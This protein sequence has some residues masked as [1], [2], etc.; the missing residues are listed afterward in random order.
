MTE[1]KTSG[2]YKYSR[3]Y[4]VII[5]FCL[6]FLIIF[7]PLAYGA[8]EPR[9][10]AVFESTAAFMALIW[11]LKMLRNGE[12]T[13][14][15]NP[16]NPLILFFIF[17]I[18]L[19][20][21]F[22]RN[23]HEAIRLPAGQA[24]YTLPYSIY[25]WATKTELLKIISYAL[26]FFVTK[27]TIR[28]PSQITRIIS[29]IMAV[30][31]ILSVFYLVRYLGV[32]VPRGLIN[33][34]HLS[35][36]LA[37]AISLALGFIFVY[38]LDTNRYT[39]T[40]KRLLLFFS[41]IVMG[42][43]L[44]FTMSRGGMFSFIA[45]L[46]FM[47]VLILTRK[48]IRSKGWIISMVAVLIVLTIAWLGA[49]PVIER[50]L[51]IKVEIASRY[52]GGRLPVWQ[53]TVGII[54]DYILF[55]TGLG[56]FNYIFPKYQPAEIMSAH[57]AYAHSDILEFLSEVGIIAFGFLVCMLLVVV[58]YLLR[59]FNNRRDPWVVGISIGL[60]GALTGIF[61]H[62]F[63][64]FNLHIPA[65]AI[66]LCV[67]LALFIGILNSYYRQENAKF[68]T[69]ITDRILLTNKLHYTVCFLTVIA[70]LVFIISSIK[71]AIADYYFHKAKDTANQPL[72]AIRYTLTAIKFDPENA[73]YH[74][75]LGRL[76]FKEA[77]NSKGQKG[78]S[79][80]LLNRT[81]ESY[82]KAIEL[83]HSN[84]KYRQSLAWVYGQ[85]YNLCKQSI[86]CSQTKAD[87]YKQK[88]IE[89]FE[90]AIKLEPHN[91]YRH[92]VYTVWFLSEP[93]T[94]EQISFRN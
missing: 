38:S 63:T 42:A 46:I 15:K 22:T 77:T 62:S 9:A 47:A 23:T 7:T 54:K 92:N 24:G 91:I 20:L 75:E 43:A 10:I 8:V 64:D 83:N 52:F 50:I 57:Y 41:V 81:V 87:E 94:R 76:Y 2:V 59:N 65:N 90:T 39:L 16:V 82:E 34:D 30:G 78:R 13:Y 32:K 21:F 29:F 80:A 89:E 40:A 37:M 6:F 19:Q 69:V 33:R 79:I 51:S 70:L 53:G 3:D 4:D 56:A 25:P 18:C 48:S 74:Y 45:S 61:L 85:L 68:N 67:I 93:T 44:F 49:T 73:F 26:I 72:T 5:E 17:Y 11:I 71:P 12:F 58:V 28:T 31:F 60:F 84:S 88:A 36:Y 27:N 86:G 14:I 55:G 66:L 35:A 1:N